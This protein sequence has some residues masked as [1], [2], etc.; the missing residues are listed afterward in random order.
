MLTHLSCENSCLFVV[1]VACSALIC[2]NTTAVTVVTLWFQ[3]KLTNED[4]GGGDGERREGINGASS[5]TA[6]AEQMQEGQDDGGSCA[7]DFIHHYN[8]T[9]ILRRLFCV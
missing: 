3:V 9:N 1:C 7:G 4:L 8:K 2:V 5:T 6:A